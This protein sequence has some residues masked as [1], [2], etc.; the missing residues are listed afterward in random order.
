V[1]GLRVIRVKNAASDTTSGPRREHDSWTDLETW[2]RFF[3][4]F[5]KWSNRFARA[6]QI[7]TAAVRRTLRHEPAGAL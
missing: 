6:R 5:L 4:Q 7:T 2:R 1:F 3:E